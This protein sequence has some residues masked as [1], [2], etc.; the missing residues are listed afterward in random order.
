MVTLKALVPPMVQHHQA[1]L[2]G[3][4]VQP[5]TD[6]IFVD[7]DEFGKLLWPI[8]ALSF[9]PPVRGTHHQVLGEGE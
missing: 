5:S 8:S 4:P 6:R 9:G 2:V 3:C 7:L 1:T